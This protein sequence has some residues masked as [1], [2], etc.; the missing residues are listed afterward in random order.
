MEAAL[1]RARQTD[2]SFGMVKLN[3]IMFNAEFH[4][5]S[6]TGDPITGADYQALEQGPALRRM[7]PLVIELEQETAL[8]IKHES[9]GELTRNRP[10]AL[11]TPDLGWFTADELSQIETGITE[12]WGKSAKDM[13][14]V[15]HEFVGWKLSRIGETIPYETVFAMKPRPLTERERQ[16]GHELIAEASSGAS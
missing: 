11:R 3:K 2:E 15:S 7:V 1:E 8:A 13:S 6:R 4:M 16:I 5:Y 9:V 10:I 12:A 14:E